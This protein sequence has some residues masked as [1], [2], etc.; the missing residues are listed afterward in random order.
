E[1]KRLGT[2]TGHKAE[3]IP[4]PHYG[5]V[6]VMLSWSDSGVDLDLDLDM[7]ASVRDVQSCMMEHAYVESE[8]EIY[9]GHYPVNVANV[10]D[11]EMSED[12]FVTITT[13]GE[14]KVLRIDANTTG[15]VADIVVKYVD[16]KP[17]VSL[18]FDP[19]VNI[20]FES[21]APYT[22]SS[23]GRSGGGGV[24]RGGGGTARYTPSSC[25]PA[26]SCGCME[27]EYF[28][29]P[30]LAR[31][32]KGPLSGADISL[33]SASGYR[34]DTALYTGKTSQGTEFYTAGLLNIPDE[35]ITSLQDDEPYIIEVSGGTDID[36]NDDMEADSVFTQN[37]ATLH[38]VLG[39]AD[40]K[41]IKPKVSIL[42]EIAYQIIHDHLISGE[43]TGKILETLDDIA[44]R[45]LR[46]KIYPSSPEGI[47]HLDL[48]HW[49]PTIDRD[50]LFTSYE[51]RI[52]PIIDKLQRNE[53]IYQDAYS[54]VYYPESIIPIVQSSVFN[55]P[56]DAVENTVIGQVKVLNEGASPVTGFR[57]SGYESELF[58]IDENGYIALKGMLDY[59]TQ[60]RYH[61][62]VRAQNS[63]GNSQDTEI[64]IQVKDILD[65]PVITGFSAPV[66]YSSL[67]ADTYA[68]K[69]TFFPGGGTVNDIS[70]SGN[71]SEYFDIDPEGNIMISRTLEN[72][73]VKKSYSITVRVVNE[74]G[75]SR[76]ATIK[77]HVADRKELP[78][79]KGFDANI[80]ENSPGGTYIGKIEILSTGLSDIE[81]FALYG[82]QSQDWT[83]NN[84]GEIYVAPNAQIDFEKQQQYKISVL[85]HNSYG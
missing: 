6:E 4:D 38:A 29:V 56:E 62:K 82:V 27:C 11:E 61:L 33:F 25:S 67:P 7:P 79:I 73:Q 70:V 36:R 77:F 35:L 52:L 84:S 2:V 46:G 10:S 18:D 55:V 83:I 37:H 20:I 50:L 32:I 49:L 34:T 47:T 63:H 58:D 22:P 66:L 53:D 41:S 68:G 3:E 12:Y 24:N 76:P 59:E 85:A 42:T 78:V 30:Y 28:V 51:N 69:I 9:P 40:L 81:Y 60:Q 71:D 17:V 16:D 21:S 54:I 65:A 48:A 64:Y 15:H 43:E 72:Y 57:L 26:K 23:G 44:N 75:E 31:V 19:V 74:F 45:L 14:T 8:Y 13:P 39:G 80:T 1:S 5:A